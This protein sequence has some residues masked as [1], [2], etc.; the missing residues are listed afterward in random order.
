VPLGGYLQNIKGKGKMNIFGKTHVLL[1]LAAVMLAS[2]GSG[3]L[4]PTVSTALAETA[5]PLPTISFLTTT[6]L[7]TVTPI[8][9]T[10]T[11]VPDPTSTPIFPPIESFVG[12]WQNVDANTRN[13]AKIEITNNEDTLSARFVLLCTLT[14]EWMFSLY[15]D[16]LICDE[17]T[18]SAMYGGNP[19][20]MF[21]DHGSATYNF[22][23]LLNGDTLHVT[24]FMDYTD[25]SG[26]A[27][28]TL[29]D[30]F[31]KLVPSFPVSDQIVFYHFVD[32]AYHFIPGGSVITPMPL[33]PASSDEPHTSDTAA[34]LR[35]ALELVLQDERNRWTSSDLEIVDLMFREG[36]AD[37]V[38]QGEY[39]G[40]SEEVLSAARI[41]ILMT[42]FANPSVQTATVTLNGDTIG[43]LGV[44]SSTDAKPADYVYTRAEMEMY[45]IEHV[46]R[47]P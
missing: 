12:M 13:W 17:D 26:S 27:D 25:N 10:P 37:I 4:T 39:S 1:F 33:F 44:S 38:L 21:S 35:T 11:L 8:P 14:E 28:K 29:E 31:R 20:L 32:R 23:L 2:C 47:E 36:H 18:V 34:D 46:F 6:P 43:N 3:Q 15:P 7:P 5:R 41:Q 9:P 45:L 19:V 30:D 40:E 16:G 22:T 24:T 42:V